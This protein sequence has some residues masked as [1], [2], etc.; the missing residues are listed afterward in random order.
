MLPCDSCTKFKSCAE[1][2]YKTPIKI[3]NVIHKCDLIKKTLKINRSTAVYF[4][5]EPDE[6]TEKLMIE[7]PDTFKLNGSYIYNRLVSSERG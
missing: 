1:I 6:V 2:V 5:Y 7:L 4:E 3:F